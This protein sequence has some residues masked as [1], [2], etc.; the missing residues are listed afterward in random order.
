M[1]RQR[2]YVYCEAKLLL[3][4]TLLLDDSLSET[5]T[6]KSGACKSKTLFGVAFSGMEMDAALTDL[7]TV[8]YRTLRA[9]WIVCYDDAHAMVDTSCDGRWRK[10]RY[11]DDQRFIRYDRKSCRIRFTTH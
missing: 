3:A 11:Y 1:S 6:A 5:A 9:V 10:Q 7:G 2:C 4:V 8:R